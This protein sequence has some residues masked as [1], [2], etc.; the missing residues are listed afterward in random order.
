MCDFVPIPHPSPS[1]FTSSLKVKSKIGEH[2]PTEIFFWGY[3]YI[4]I[5]TLNFYKLFQI[6][7]FLY[8]LTVIYLHCHTTLSLDNSLL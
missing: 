1:I 8:Y 3:L 6:Y 5:I 4:M 7:K 2:L